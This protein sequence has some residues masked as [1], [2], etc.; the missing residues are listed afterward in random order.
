MKK[1]LLSIALIGTVIMVS[2]SSEKKAENEDKDTAIGC[3]ILIA[4]VLFFWI[5]IEIS[6]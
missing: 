4:I 3:A 5:I 2:C 1:L 6:S